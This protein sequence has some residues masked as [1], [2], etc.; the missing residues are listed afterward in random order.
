MAEDV[1]ASLS[2]PE[3]AAFY[4]RLA[5]GVDKRKGALKASLAA[6][7]MRLWLT[8]RDKDANLTIDAPEHLREHEQTRATLAHHRRVFLTEEKA[9]RNGG[10]V[11]AGVLPRLKGIAPHTKW[12]CRRP[13]KIEYESLLEFPLRYQLTGNDAD[14]DLL[15]SLH[16]CQL[17]STVTVVGQP[18]NK[19]GRVM[20]SFQA[21]ETYAC[22]RYDWDYSEHLTVPNP[23]FGSTAKGT[24]APKSQTVVVYHKNAK[25]LEDARLAAPYRFQTKPWRVTHA[26]L[27]AVAEVDL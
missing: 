15:Y 10:D 20:I 8:N 26:A 21:F 9:H 16:G 6:M 4:G 7:L 14:R 27:N 13:V 1:L 19:N 25:R 23:D 12:D 3:L 11:W 2:L 17:H 22:D 18:G 5:D 24:V